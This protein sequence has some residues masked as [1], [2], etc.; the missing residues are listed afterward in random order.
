MISFK[1]RVLYFN[2]KKLRNAE[3]WLLHRLLLKQHKCPW[4]PSSRDTYCTLFDHIRH[5]ELHLQWQSD[6]SSSSYIS[7]RCHNASTRLVAL[8]Y[9]KL[10]IHDLMISLVVIY[11]SNSKKGL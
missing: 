4:L 1:I 7:L 2:I 10:Q 9:L 5:C 3:I 11:C 6:I 8:L